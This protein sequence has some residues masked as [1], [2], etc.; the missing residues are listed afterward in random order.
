M[1]AVCPTRA[2]AL[3]ESLRQ[4]I[5]FGIRQLRRNPAFAWTA[6][7]TL[8]LGIGA[9]TAIF[10]AV[11]A[12]LL[13]PL[14]YPAPDRLMFVYQHTKYDDMSAM[15]GQDFF[16]APSTLHSFESVAGYLDPGDENLTSAGGPMRVTVNRVSANFC[17][18]LRVTPALGRNFLSSEDHVGGRVSQ[19]LAQ[20]RQEMAIRLA[21]GSSRPELLRLIMSQAMRLILAG[22]IVGIVGAWFLDRLLASMLVG[23]KAHDPASLSLAW[24]LMTLIALVGSCVPARNAAHTSVISILHS[25]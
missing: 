22:G 13:R 18:T 17:P 1:Q 25:E 14:S 4:D 19:S 23:V 7:L 8:A 15:P 20:R 12:L 6:I 11:Y 16:A 2:G 9:T 24:G 21:L 5:R 10:F 3:A